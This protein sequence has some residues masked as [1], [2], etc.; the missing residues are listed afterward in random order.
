MPALPHPR[1]LPTLHEDHRR[2]E[3][4]PA[5]RDVQKNDQHDHAGPHH[6]RPVRTAGVDG[7]GD[8]EAAEDDDEEGIAERERVDGETP[9]AETPPRVG[10]GLVPEATEED[11][12]DGEHVGG[13]E[14]EENEGDDDV[15]GEGGAEVDE[16]EDGGAEGAG[17]GWD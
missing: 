10:E 14:G 3:P 2:G 7:H 9:P 12:P 8:G 13:E 5:M 1:A 11:A 4:F 15:E 16:A 17:R 6:G